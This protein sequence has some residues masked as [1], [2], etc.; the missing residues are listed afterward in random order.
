[1][2]GFITALLNADVERA[3]ELLSPEELSVVHDYGK[4]ILDRVHYS[5]TGVKVRSVEFA[6][7]KGSDGT[8]VRIKSA[9]VQTSDGDT[10]KASVDGDC[11]TVTVQGKTQRMCSSNLIEQLGGFGGSLTAAQ[12]TALS[13][14]V[15]GITKATG[16]ETSQVGGKWYVNPLRS[17]FTLFNALL[18]G[19]Q[20]DDAKELLKLIGS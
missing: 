13:H 18:S 19:L 20:G 10:I 2:R 5:P 1:V 17:Y 8:R 4:L 12:R 3:G 14:L 11:A 7:E 16:I 15:S 6:D 9:E